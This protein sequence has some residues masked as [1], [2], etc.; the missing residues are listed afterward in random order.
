ME[1]VLLP[2]AEEDLSFWVKSGNKTILRK[3]SELTRAIIDDPYKGTGKPEAL[4]YQLVGKWSRRISN[5]HRYVYSIEKDT[6]K[7]Y[8]LKGHY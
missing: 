5:E 4:K 8:S 2:K 7:I 6:L 1:I 3:I